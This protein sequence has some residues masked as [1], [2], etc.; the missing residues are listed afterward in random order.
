MRDAL[1]LR[2]AINIVNGTD[3]YASLMVQEQA[4]IDL[5]QPLGTNDTIKFNN[6]PGSGVQTIEPTMSLPTIAS[7]VTI[8]GYSQSVAAVATKT[9]PAT[10]LIQLDGEIAGFA[11]SLS[12]NASNVTIDGLAINRFKS[13]CIKHEY[14]DLQP[15]NNVIR[16]NSHRAE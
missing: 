7:A 3:S 6:I 16:G 11:D 2:E 15:I 13:N 9:T 8:D 10:I 4:Q 12:I 5:T 14:S 1:T